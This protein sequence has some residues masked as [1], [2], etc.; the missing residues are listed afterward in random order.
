MPSCQCVTST[1]CKLKNAMVFFLLLQWFVVV[2]VRARARVCGC[3]CVC[4]GVCVGVRVLAY[5]A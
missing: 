4:V 1:G 2:V 5:I 3:V